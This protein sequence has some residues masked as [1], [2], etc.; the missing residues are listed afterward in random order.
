MSLLF[1]YITKNN[2]RILLLTL[3]VGFCLYILTDLFERL[4]NF[5]EANVPIHIILTYFLV[6]TP[7]AIAQILPVIFLI[8]TIIQLCIMTKNKELMALNVGGISFTQITHIILICGLFWGSIQFIFSEYIGIVGGK[9]SLRI[10]QES[11][12]KRNLSKA[13]VKD[14]WFTNKDWIVSISILKPD[15]TGIG[16]TAYLLDQ[17]GLNIEKI[18][19]ASSVTVQQNIW[20][21]YNV[22]IANPTAYTKEFLQEFPLPITQ[23]TNAL[24]IVHT[25][26]TP[27]QLPIWELNKAIN[28]LELSG[29]NVEILK[30]AW[31]AKFAYAFSLVVMAILATAIVAWKNNIYIAIILSLGYTFIY[32]AIYTLGISLAEK[33]ILPPVIGAWLAN[34]ISLCIAGW[35]IFFTS[36]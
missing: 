30:T 6:K 20:K 19:W 9:E 36:K 21:L 35:K 7:F 1:R 12:R 11:V 13:N 29:S 28:K 33:G 34:G 5:I 26:D 3:T 17:Q 24:R 4:E 22:L 32:Y 25:K 31:H 15:D 10:W 16:L 2:A 18:I 14:I 23:S 27:Q 8:S